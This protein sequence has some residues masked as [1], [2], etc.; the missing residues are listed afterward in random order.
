M[1]QQ[2]QT[3]KRDH[4]DIGIMLGMFVLQGTDED[5]GQGPPEPKNIGRNKKQKTD[6]PTLK[7]RGPPV[8]NP[9]GPSRSRRSVLLRNHTLP[10]YFSLKE[11]PHST[12]AEV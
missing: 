11:S 12:Q 3:K 9:W 10:A 6:I 7:M 5:K 2:V 8:P 1:V 4:K